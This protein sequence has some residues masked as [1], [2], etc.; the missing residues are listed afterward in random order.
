MIEGPLGGAAFNNEFGRPNIL[1]YFRTFEAEVPAEKGAEV[2]GYHK[3]I[4]LA[5]GLGNI[6]EDHIAKGN[7]NLKTLDRFRWPCYAYWFRSRAAS[8]VASGSGNEDLILRVF[9][10]KIQKCNAVV[11]K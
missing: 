7:I 1:G 8:S 6:K 3:P 11:K 4:M 10:A 5:G 2:R 9:S